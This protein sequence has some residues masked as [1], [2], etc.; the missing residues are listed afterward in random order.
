MKA[1]GVS[2]WEGPSRLA[3]RILCLYT[4]GQISDEVWALTKSLVAD[5]SHAEGHDLFSPTVKL[6]HVFMKKVFAESGVTE[7]EVDELFHKVSTYFL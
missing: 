4:A 7:E 6:G 3:F 1:Q 2:L 5:L